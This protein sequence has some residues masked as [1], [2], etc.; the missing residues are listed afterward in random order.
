M[1]GQFIR[2]MPEA[3]DKAMSWSWMSKSDLKVTTEALICSAQEQAL[4]TNY[5][6][7]KIDKTSDS[8]LCRL[9]GTKPE[10]ISHI[11]SEC[12]TLAQKEYKPTA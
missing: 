7:F 1:Y 6:K 3:T 4:R 10:T 11:I 2:E 12:K 8:P 9:C 5:T